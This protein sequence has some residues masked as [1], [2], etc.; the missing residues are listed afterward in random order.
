MTR[1]V[2]EIWILQFLYLCEEMIWS[3]D[4]NQSETK[5]IYVSYTQFTPSLNR[6][7]ETTFQKL[8]VSSFLFVVSCQGSGS[9]F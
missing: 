6:V 9:K 1:R 2:S 3:G 8:T 5:F 7:L 4:Q